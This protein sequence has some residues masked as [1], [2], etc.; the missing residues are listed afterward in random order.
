MVDT[1]N[2]TLEERLVSGVGIHKLKQYNENMTKMMDTFLKRFGRKPLCH[3]TLIKRRRKIFTWIVFLMLP[4]LFVHQP[5]RKH[6]LKLM[7][8]WWVNTASWTESV[9]KNLELKGTQSHS[10]WKWSY[11]CKHS[12]QWSSVNWRT[13]ISC[14][15]IKVLHLRT[16]GTINY[17]CNQ[18]YNEIVARIKGLCDHSYMGC[19][20]LQLSVWIVHLNILITVLC[21]LLLCI[22][23]SLLL[24]MELWHTVTT[25]C[26]NTNS[27]IS[28]RIY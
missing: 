27:Y 25:H 9:Q 15:A 22:A 5:K 16:F 24:F 6:V 1:S 8:Q 18:S 7:H 3:Q 12:G 21:Y 28:N 4:T 20:M 2:F 11:A 10:T 17:K 23:I 13:K 14:V 26:I 19:V